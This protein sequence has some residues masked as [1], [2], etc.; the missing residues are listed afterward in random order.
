MKTGS[1]F[2][3]RAGEYNGEMQICAYFNTET[4]RLVSRKGTAI[5]G[6]REEVGFP[7]E[8]LEARNRP[9]EQPALIQLRNAN[10][11]A[12]VRSIS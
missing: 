5:R 1:H 9:E 3:I 7:Q 11:A 2:N 4:R 12:I 6:W 10:A 8:I